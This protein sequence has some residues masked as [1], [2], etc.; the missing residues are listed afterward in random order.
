MTTKSSKTP[1]KRSWVKTTLKIILVIVILFFL[2]MGGASVYLYYKGNDLIKGYLV[3]TVERSSKGIYHL[4]LEKLNINLFNGRI[5]LWGFHL[6]PDTTLYNQLSLTDTL[7]PMLIDVK[8]DK[9]QVR[10]FTLR[11]ILLNR[12]VD[13]SMILI[14]EPEIMVIL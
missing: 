1:G 2:L 10:G 8:I 13:I 11:D 7:S 14:N 3:N 6:I 4:E 12:Q 9:F 5:N